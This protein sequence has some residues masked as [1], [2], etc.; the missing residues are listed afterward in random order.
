MLVNR[1]ALL[2]RA[3]PTWILYDTFVH[4]RGE[5]TDQLSAKWVTDRQSLA[6]QRDP[7]FPCGIPA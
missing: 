7:T 6:Q 5:L 2:K 1:E 4:W 3:K